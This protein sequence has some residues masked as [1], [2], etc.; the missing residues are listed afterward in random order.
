MNKNEFRNYGPN[1]RTFMQNVITST[2]QP[3]VI[4]TEDVVYRV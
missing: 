1:I 4:S 3:D 2:M